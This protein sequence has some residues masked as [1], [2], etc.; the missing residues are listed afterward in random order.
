[1]SLS[2]A[3]RLLLGGAGLLLVFGACSDSGSPKVGSADANLSPTTVVVASPTV[4]ALPSIPTTTAAGA[5]APAAVDGPTL[6]QSA[7]A[8][9]GGGY[10]FNQ[11]N[12]VDGVVALTVDGDRL[13][14]GARLAVRGDAGL[15]FYTI[16]PDGT[17]LMPENGEW[18]VD[19]S[20][21]P[22]VDPIAA[23]SAPTSVAVASNDG[24]TVQL[25]V[26]VPFAA[27]GLTGD[28]DAPLQVSIVNGALTTI[29]YSTTTPDGKAAA[30]TTAIG[31][32]VDPSPVVAPI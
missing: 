6:L 4:S 30:A 15:V 14:D 19:D 11:T 16:T 24:T 26:N 13:P 21:P 22:T 32:V 12:T 17:W 27:L 10:H 28:G 1:M 7:I 2:K 23:I 8:A 31:A 20:D 29:T 18:E 5:L 9:T 3:A 25:V